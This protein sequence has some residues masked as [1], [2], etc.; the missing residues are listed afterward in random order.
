MPDNKENN[1]ESIDLTPRDYSQPFEVVLDEIISESG[2]NAADIVECITCSLSLIQREIKEYRQ[3][4]NGIRAA[5]AHGAAYRPECVDP[6]FMDEI[7]HRQ[8]LIEYLSEYRE[9]I[10][11]SKRVVQRMANDERWQYLVELGLLDTTK[12]KELTQSTSQD[13]R[14]KLIGRILQ[15]PDE[16]ARKL[17]DSS[18]TCNKSKKDKIKETLNKGTF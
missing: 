6:D 3:H 11:T 16:S 18:R 13:F 2:P 17:L 15:I 8:K 12:W 14:D 5:I 7:E 10:R 1:T 4:E 9:G